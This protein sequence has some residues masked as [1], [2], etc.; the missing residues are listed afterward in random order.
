[1]SSATNAALEKAQELLWQNGN[2]CGFS[3]QELWN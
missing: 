2:S 3:Y 1:L